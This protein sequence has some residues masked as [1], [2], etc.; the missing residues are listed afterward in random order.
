VV[1]ITKM[2]KGAG[3][4]LLRCVVPARGSITVNTTVPFQMSTP[5]YNKRMRLKV[6]GCAAAVAAFGGNKLLSHCK[7]TCSGLNLSQNLEGGPDMWS[8][9]YGTGGTT[10][11][12]RQSTGGGILVMTL[13]TSATGG[14]SSG[15]NFQSVQ[16]EWYDLGVI[17]EIPSRFTMRADCYSVDGATASAQPQLEILMEVTDAVVD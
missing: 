9:G 16:S 15:T 7:I 3:A 14:D 5:L 8:R 12:E 2:I 1:V 13:I 17:H 6:L 11:F 4:S 10:D